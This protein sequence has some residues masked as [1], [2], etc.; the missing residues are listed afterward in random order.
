MQKKFPT[1]QSRSC[2]NQLP[3][4]FGLTIQ[5]LFFVLLC[6]L[7]IPSLASDLCQDLAPYAPKVGRSANTFL[8]RSG[9]VAFDETGNVLVK[10]HQ[11]SPKSKKI[12][13]TFAPE[14]FQPASAAGYSSRVLPSGYQIRIGKKVFTMRNV[15]ERKAQEVLAVRS[16]MEG[17]NEF[18][19]VAIRY[20]TGKV[21]LT[22]YQVRNSG[23]HEDLL[24]L[25]YKNNVSLDEKHEELKSFKMRG[26]EIY[27]LGVSN[28]AGTQQSS[29]RKVDL[30][31]IR[32]DVYIG[33]PLYKTDGLVHDFAFVGDTLFVAKEDQ[34]LEAVSLKDN[35]APVEQFFAQNTITSVD[36]YGEYLVFAVWNSRTNR[37]RI[38]LEKSPLSAIP[39]R[40]N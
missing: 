20:N 17:R 22:Q 13:R 30:D 35:S 5:T 24:N 38:H 33:E 15:G 29:I 23:I 31:D 2:S 39:K 8:V 37:S 11:V 26:K 19:L 1:I 40:M 18:L 3:R 36:S 34:G 27:L 4:P 12:E 7:S 9:W 28:G 25:S 14:D 21:T 10:N 16:W 32:W 6:V